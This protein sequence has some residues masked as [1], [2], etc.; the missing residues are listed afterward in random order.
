MSFSNFILFITI[1][2]AYIA[3]PGPA[4]F[5]AINYALNCGIKKTA[6]LLLGNSLGLG[7][8][9]FISAIGIGAIIVASAFLTKL[10]QIIGALVLIYMGV[11][12]ILKA[13]HL[14]TINIEVKSCSKDYFSYFKEGLLLALTNPKPI[15]FFTSIYPQFIDFSANISN[16]IFQ[17]FILGITFMALS[18]LILNLYAL[19]SKYILG[20]FLTKDFLKIFNYISGILL[21]FIA[22]LLIAN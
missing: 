9:A 17:F 20:N 19:I 12:M 14:K 15:I 7:I 2:V 6:I 22:I 16:L 3:S 13:Y 21:I 1:A 18:F 8:L 4:V 11:K 10:L 5:I